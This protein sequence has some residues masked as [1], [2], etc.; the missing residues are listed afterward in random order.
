MKHYI[1]VNTKQYNAIVTFF[2]FIIC[3]RKIKKK[4]TGA[5]E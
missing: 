5:S 4:I 1:K 2:F 3:D